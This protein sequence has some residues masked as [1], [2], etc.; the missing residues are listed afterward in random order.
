MPISWPN[1]G[2]IIL[3]IL[4]WAGIHSSLQEKDIEIFQSRILMSEFPPAVIFS[5]SVIYYLIPSG[6]YLVMGELPTYVSKGPFW[7][8]MQFVGAFIFTAASVMWVSLLSEEKQTVENITDRIFENVNW[9]YS[10]FSEE[11]FQ[12]D[13]DDN[14]SPV[15][16]DIKENG[17][18]KEEKQTDSPRR[19]P[20]NEGN[21]NTTSDDINAK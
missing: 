2:F 12:I 21:P 15:N 5:F 6:W 18:S 3:T 9:E 10:E 8:I 4:A 11:D 17:K 19:N 20:E 14:T 7:P 16:G 1:V 13:H